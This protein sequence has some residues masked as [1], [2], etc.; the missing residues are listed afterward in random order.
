MKRRVL[1]GSFAGLLLTTLALLAGC[2]GSGGGLP[3]GGAGGGTATVAVAGTLSLPVGANATS[4]TL[5]TGFSEVANPAPNFQATVPAAAPTLVSVMHPSSKRLMMVG[6]IDPHDPSPKIDSKN[7]AATLLFLARGGSQTPDRAQLWNQILTKPA[8]ATLA[9]VVKARLDADNFT[10][11]N[12]DPALK[13]AIAT[14]VAAMGPIPSPAKR[15]TKLSEVR[16]PT[17]STVKPPPNPALV[18][19]LEFGF[20]GN[21]VEIQRAPLDSPKDATLPDYFTLTNSTPLEKAAYLFADTGA[22]VKKNVGPIFVGWDIASSANIGPE[23][24]SLADPTQ[25][26]EIQRYIVLQPVFD[27]PE[28]AL[29]Q[30]PRY[31]GVL[32]DMHAALANMRQR[33]VVRAASDILL[34][35]MGLG[36][37]TYSHEGISQVTAGFK[38]IN[39]QFQA[40]VNA[41]NAGVDL[42]GILDG[43]TDVATAS[44]SNSQAAVSVLKAIAPDLDMGSPLRLQAAREIVRISHLQGLSTFAAKYGAF[45]L[46]HNYSSEGN[47]EIADEDSDGR[48]VHVYKFQPELTPT[49]TSYS[50]GGAPIKVELTKVGTKF[51]ERFGKVLSYHWKLFGAGEATL[52]DDSSNGREF[53]STLHKVTFT[54][55]AS[56]SGAQNISLEIFVHE[57]SL[58]RPFKKVTLVLN[59]STGYDFKLAKSPVLVR[60][61]QTGRAT[62]TLNGSGDTSQWTGIDPTHLKFKWE[63]TSSAVGLL[64]NGA[65]TGATLETTKNEVFF[66]PKAGVRNWDKVGFKVTVR[67]Q[68]PVTQQFTVLGAVNGEFMIHVL[69]SAEM[70][71][72][73]LSFPASTL[74][75]PSLSRLLRP[76]E[77]TSIG[78]DASGWFI[79]GTYNDGISLNDALVL[80][81]RLGQSPKVGDDIAI[82]PATN[83]HL[84]NVILYGTNPPWHAD[85]ACTGQ[86]EIT[87]II[88]SPANGDVIYVLFEVTV[89]GADTF[90]SGRTL[91][92]RFAAG[93]GTYLP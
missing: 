11:S 9:S 84:A 23:P 49:A 51:L 53:D 43:V 76:L 27:A 90:G 82:T 7:M 28:P 52:S 33:A 67:L 41:A 14:A 60:P 21:A 58:K 3:G 8:T 66:Q 40:A 56:A 59:S 80:G 4:V 20:F 1:W 68:D 85:F 2:G 32:A 29:L 31:A 48:V 62:V 17:T 24:I 88:R 73:N 44:E 91:S 72:S 36:G 45:F 47:H 35:A 54:P 75:N 83:G 55:K 13:A 12:G 16:Q 70:Q 30:Q 50:P 46:F 92:A 57:G 63:L 10:L 5:V 34:D 19:D 93:V 69:T 78:R 18:M 71:L 37:S 77:P 38:A 22:T 42:E 25:L 26:S 39:G 15:N 89:T 74:R 6:M 64:V 87:E 79:S 86:A 65:Q 81:L 61:D